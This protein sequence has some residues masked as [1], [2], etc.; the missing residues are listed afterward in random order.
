MSEEIGVEEKESPV[1]TAAESQSV[2]QP[3]KKV[4]S[5]RK[6]T[7]KPRRRVAARKKAAPIKT[8]PPDNQRDALRVEPSLRDATEPWRP[9]SILTA[10]KIPGMVSRWCSKDLMEKRMAEGWSPRRATTRG[11]ITSGEKTLIDGSPMGDYVTKRNMV[12]C[13]MPDALAEGRKKYFREINE[14]GLKGQENQFRQDT[15]IDGRSYG[16]GAIEVKK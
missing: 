13:D 15:A 1:P 16:Y 7:M 2:E 8:E 12:L 10:E 11:R 4:V 14:S 3:K 6:I 9:A 5:R